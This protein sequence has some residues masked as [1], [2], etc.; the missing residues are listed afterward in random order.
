MRLWEHISEKHRNRYRLLLLTGLFLFIVFLNQD[1]DF[2]STYTGKKGG[3]GEK[4]ICDEEADKAMKRGDYGVGIS[5]HEVIL[6]E[7]PKNV[8]ALYHLGYAYGKIGNHSME[9]HY[10]ERAVSLGLRSDQIYFNLAMA[11]GEMNQRE[12]SVEALKKA[13]EINPDNADYHFELAMAYLENIEKI[14]V[15]QEFLRVTELDNRHVEAR[16]ILSRLYNE[17]GALQKAADKIEEVL[18]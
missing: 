9:V 6:E 16:L 17:W 11:Y 2:W 5:L 14:L 12:K 13:L 4:W 15:E 10:Y 7:H 8:L 18:N 1:L 3:P